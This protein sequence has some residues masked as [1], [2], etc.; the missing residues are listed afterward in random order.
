MKVIFHSDFY[1]VYDAYE[2]AA[3]AGRMEAVIECLGDRFAMLQAVAAEPQDIEAVHSVGHI[4]RVRRQGLYDIAALAAGGAVQ[5]ATIG[6][7]EPAF[8]LIRPPG[9]HASQD[10]SWGFCYFNN[11]A[12]ALTRLLA[13]GRIKTAAVLD[14][15][16]HYGDGNV[17]ILSGKSAVHICNPEESDRKAYLEEVKFFLEGLHV[18]AIGISAGFD[19]HEKDWGGLLTT[20]D[21]LDMGRMVRETAR[22]IGAGYFGILEGGYNHNV[23]GQNVLALL[24]GMS[25]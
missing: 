19:N 7:R 12:V 10:D 9:H 13:D 18:D 23:L 3:A 1:S 6:L 21:Y 24:E 5:A 22:K 14:F 4:E 16:L 15:D 8:A 20:G 17:N 25:G 11:M 2:P